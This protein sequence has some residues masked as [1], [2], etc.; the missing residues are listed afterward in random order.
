MPKTEPKKELPVLPFA[1]QAAWEKWLAREHQKSD[2]V[3]LKLAKKDS[4][5][6]SVTYAEAVEVAL[7]YGWIDGQSKRVDDEYFVQRF[8]PRRSRS[9]WSK[10]NVGKVD[11]LTAAGKMKPAG[12]A[13]VERAKADGRW[14]AAYASP[15]NVTVPDDLLAALE[16]N[17]KAKAFFE[18]LDRTNRYAVL[19]RIHGAKKP[20]TRARRI[21]E[22]VKM[23]AD[24]GLLHPSRAKK[25]G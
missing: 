11:A 10:I 8:T 5:I 12:L 20:E 21:A 15:R 14:D 19:F 4:G 13:E 25:A 17:K 16:K 9:I 6:P 23:L 18:Q 1:S 3:L 22:F 2:G 24:Q 7:C